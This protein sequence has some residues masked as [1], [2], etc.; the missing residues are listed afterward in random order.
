MFEM[1]RTCWQY[2]TWNFVLDVC[3]YIIVFKKKKLIVVTFL[4][5]GMDTF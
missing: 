4:L 5:Q 1:Y 3:I 2:R